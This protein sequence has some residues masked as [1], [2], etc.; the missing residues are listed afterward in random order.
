VDTI[1]RVEMLVL[2][3]GLHFLVWGLLGARTGLVE[4]H[5]TLAN[6]D[7]FGPLMVI[8]GGL[9]S[10]LILA[11]K[12]RWLRYVLGFTV[13]LC[14]VGT[15]ASFARGAFLAAVAV[16]GVVWL[17]SP[18]KGRMA[19]GML[20]AGVVLAVAAAVL[21]GD[22]YWN[23][24]QTILEGTEEQTGE[25]RWIMWGAAFRVW[26]T[27][28][29]LGVGI[30]N[31]GAFA[32]EYF[33][34]GDLAGV[35]GDNPSMLWGR[36]P[37]NIYIQMLAEQ[38][39]VGVVAFGWLF[40]DA[41]R[42]NAELR[43]PAAVQAWQQAG[44]RLRLDTVALGMEAA[45]VGALSAGVF[46]PILPYHWL[47]TLLALNLVVHRTFVMT[48]RGGGPPADHPGIR[49]PRRAAVAT[50]GPSSPPLAPPV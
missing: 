39:I 25:D 15:V 46:Y 20:G 14:V 41:W 18:N 11:T 6:Y 3:F 30:E 1:R 16:A 44:G 38:G 12:Q 40:R 34:P 48:V 27:H 7:G 10:F 2:A 31:V 19:A 13:A 24:M 45:L 42:R 4:W 23:E 32:A 5:P 21:Y 50:P 26:F 28:P 35:Y 17:R 33:Q 49:R 47:W 37:H 43:A 22:A 8:G 9:C 36:E 29:I